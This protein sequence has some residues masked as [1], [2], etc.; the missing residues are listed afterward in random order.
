MFAILA[1]A[2]ALQAMQIDTPPQPYR[3]PFLR[4]Y[5]PDVLQ[6]PRFTAYTV[7]PELLNRDD[8]AR[9]LVHNYPAELRDNRIGGTALVWL[10]VDKI[11]RTVGAL[12]KQ[13]SGIPRLDTAALR[14]A[15]VIKWK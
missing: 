6:G 4:E 2:T 12:V 13:T 15:E 3:F 11:G 1:L 7:K 10:Y 14:V 8:V 9:A 5:P